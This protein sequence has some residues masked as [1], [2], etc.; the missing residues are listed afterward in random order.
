MKKGLFITIAQKEEDVIKKFVDAGLKNLNIKISYFT[1]SSENKIIN[2]IVNNQPQV[3][4]LDSRINDDSLSSLFD[5][6]NNVTAI[7]QIY[8]RVYITD[9]NVKLPDIIPAS[10]EEIISIL[11][12]NTSG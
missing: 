1:E 12:Q 9:K 6:I 3:I 5:R 8:T 10:M 2:Q 7:N 11:N 4:I